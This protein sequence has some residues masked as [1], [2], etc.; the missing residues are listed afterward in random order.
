VI[1]ALTE[2]IGRAVGAPVVTDR[3]VRG[4]DV[5]RSYAVDLADGRTVF[6]KSHP[7]APAHFFTTEAA[8][9]RWLRDGVDPAGPIAVPEVLAV[10]DEPPNHLVL[11]WIDVV[12]PSRSDADAERRFG[13]GLAR[14][15]R[16]GAPCFGREDR[17]TT[18][19]RG[20]PNEPMPTWAAG[21]HCVDGACRSGVGDDR[22]HG[23]SWRAGV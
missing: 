6:A 10:S 20:L 12:G 4:G 15:H 16:A 2:A 19:S 14:L 3:P 9:L 8:G 1:A 22:G 17:R 5:A 23:G 11:E 18:G 21:L 13:T 7:I